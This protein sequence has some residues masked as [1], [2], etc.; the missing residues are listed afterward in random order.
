MHQKWKHW[1]V[2]ARKWL[3]ILVVLGVAAALPVGYDRVQTESTAKKVEFVFD[4]RDLL[5]ISVYQTHPQDFI[6]EQ[7]TRLQQAGVGS[8][9]LFESTLDEFVKSRRITVYDGQ[10]VADLTGKVTPTNENYTYVSFINEE[11]KNQIKPIIEETFTRLGIPVKPWTFKDTDGLILETAKQD[12]LLK[13]MS[14]DPITIA[15]LRDKGFTIVPRLSDS[16]PYDQAYMERLISYFADNGVKRLLFDGE[17]VKGF[18]DD[19]EMDSLESF[20]ELLNKYNIGLT[21]IENIKKPQKGFEK[22]AYLTDYNVVRIYSLSERD[23]S[24]KT[25]V[26]SDRFVLA[27]KDRNIRM[28]YLNAE[29]LRDTTTASITSPLDNLIESLTEPGHAI[30]DIEKNGFTIGQAEA[31]KVTDSSMQR[32]FKIGAVIGAI[33]LISLMIS[34]FIPFLTI[35]AFVLGLIGSAGLYVLNAELME[36]AL[37]LATSISGPTVAMILAVRKVNEASR[38]NT[39]KNISTGRRLSHALVLFLKT[40]ILSLAAVPLVIAL[41]N[42]VTYM[43]VLD[44][45]RGVNLLAMAPMLLTAVYVLLYR[46]GKMS[47][48]GVISLLKSPI[49]IAMVIAAGILG[50][51][52]MY[53]LSR[54]GNAGQVSSL[55]MAFRSFLEN[56]FGVRPRNKEFLFAHPIMLLGLFLSFKYRHAAYLLI[57]GAMGQLSI[58]GTFTHIHSPIYISTI[59]G[60]LGLVLGLIIGLIA[61]LVWQVGERIWKRWS[62]LLRQ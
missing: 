13:P 4:Y 61:I 44:Q 38:T 27:S 46:G 57:F 28:F 45:F 30:R 31:F 43:L 33:A 6:E 50:A 59:R 35:P 52:G 12:A 32:Y 22:L 53:Y 24:L 26:I 11:S 16:L 56:T 18:N 17:S 51:A 14:P 34:Y 2:A 15:M 36:Q 48:V 3:W 10:Q 37:A 21:A 20:G 55:E 60:L 25:N 54:T 7:L 9:A 58:V 39:N 29:P 23:A 41:L 47:R 49:N 62:H 40:T 1:N 42:N 19:E 8:M 5:D